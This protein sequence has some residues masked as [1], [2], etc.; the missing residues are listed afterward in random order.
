MKIPGLR[1]NERVR[2]TQETLIIE[3]Q[4][5]RK[6][7]LK[8]V[9]KYFVNFYAYCYQKDKKVTIAF[10]IFSIAAWIDEI[11]LFFENRG[12]IWIVYSMCIKLK[13]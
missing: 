1:R 6:G 5:S 3:K 9:F 7:S 13:P 8:K 4:E 11:R 10:T 2:T 12:L